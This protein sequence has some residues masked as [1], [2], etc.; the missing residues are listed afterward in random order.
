MLQ[1]LYDDG[2]PP[3]QKTN[4]P[5]PPAPIKADA[6]GDFFQLFWEKRNNPSVA[7]FEFAPFSTSI[8]LGL[9]RFRLVHQYRDD[10][11]YELTRPDAATR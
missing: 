5:K 3:G 8:P 4:R 1:K 9:A 11:L 6:P 2:L 10:W 7:E